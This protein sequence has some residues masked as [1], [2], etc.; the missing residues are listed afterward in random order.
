MIKKTYCVVIVVIAISISNCWGQ[1]EI[2]TNLLGIVNGNYLLTFELPYKQKGSLIVEMGYKN[3]QNG[4]VTNMFSNFNIK[5]IE[6]YIIRVG[7]GYYFTSNRKGFFAE[8]SLDV[9]Y[10]NMKLKN[11]PDNDSICAKGLILTP[12][13]IFGYKI[14]IWKLTF[15][16]LIG[17]GYHLNFMNFDKIGRWPESSFWQISNEFGYPK[18]DFFDYKKGLMPFMQF[19]ISYLLKS[20]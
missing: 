13:A 15:K 14:K 8:F 16:P 19:N 1:K 9:R 3:A 17:L 5:K 20:H 11:A 4:I 7:G 10:S 2:G 6:D 12:C 18:K